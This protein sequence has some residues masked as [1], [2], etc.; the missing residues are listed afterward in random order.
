MSR[1]RGTELYKEAARLQGA[2]GLGEVAAE[3][4]A[5]MVV[6]GPPGLKCQAGLPV[7]RAHETPP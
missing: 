7:A 6:L 5:Q 1:S 4:Q 2:D 3:D